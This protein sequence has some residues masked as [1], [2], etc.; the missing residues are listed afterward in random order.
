MNKKDLGQ[1]ETLFERLFIKGFTQIWESNLEPVLTVLQNDVSEL[2]TKVANMH[3]TVGNLENTV[4]NLPTKEYLDDKLG[5]IKA[6]YIYR[7]RK[8]NKG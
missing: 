2:Q 1:I 8:P 7:I 4:S 6:D 5:L 3:G